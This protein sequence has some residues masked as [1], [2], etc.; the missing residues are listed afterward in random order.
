ML[1]GGLQKLRHPHEKII[2]IELIAIGLSFFIGLIALIQASIFFLI[3]AFYFIVISLVCDAFSHSY[4]S[5]RQL[6]SI[7]QAIRASILFILATGLIF[8]L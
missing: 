2:R 5:N 7:K 1:E 4:T 8:L 6:Q 3:I